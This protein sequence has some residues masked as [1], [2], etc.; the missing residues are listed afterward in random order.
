MPRC[1]RG[2]SNLS[3]RR[4]QA[5]FSR[6]HAFLAQRRMALARFLVRHVRK[7]KK[8]KSA[9]WRM[10]QEDTWKQRQLAAI[11][12]RDQNDQRSFNPTKIAEEIHR[13]NLEAG[14]QGEIRS[15][16]DAVVKEAL[17]E[18][19]RMIVDEQEA[20]AKQSVNKGKEAGP[21][22]QRNSGLMAGLKDLWA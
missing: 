3:Q 15:A 17:P 5:Q 19:A 1:A 14:M 10:K 8:T 13:L 21:S 7:V 12:E 22:G 16:V 4:L 11:A 18:L 20:R 2:V 9:K 6:A